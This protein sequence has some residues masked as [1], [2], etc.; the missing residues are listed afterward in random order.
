MKRAIWLIGILLLT[1]LALAACG[2]NEEYPYTLTVKNGYIR[3]TE[4][5]EDVICMDLSKLEDAFAISPNDGEKNTWC[6][7]GE[8]VGKLWRQYL[9]R[10]IF[11]RDC[12]KGEDPNR[13]GNEG[14]YRFNF[15][16][17]NGRSGWIYVMPDG[18]VYAHLFDES[19]HPEELYTFVSEPGTADYEAI[20]S[21]YESLTSEEEPF[22]C[23]CEPYISAGAPYE[24]YLRLT[25]EGNLIF[26]HLN[27]TRYSLA[28]SELESIRLY[29]E[30]LGMDMT[31]WGS[32]ERERILFELL[33]EDI[34][35]RRIDKEIERDLWYD[36]YFGYGYSPKSLQISVDL[37]DNCM[38]VFAIA[39]NGRI[40]YIDPDGHAYISA[41]DTR[42][43][44]TVTEAIGEHY[45]SYYFKITN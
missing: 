12:E 8:L 39:R 32:L 29:G 25:E 20:S 35:F 43:F 33:T 7:S 21:F 23:D 15:D 26:G 16:F 22:G 42:N 6:Y 34:W 40:V 45:E 10:K 27:Q 38:I 28:L 44:E 30:G 11:L 36:S 37:N 14:A 18:V 19:V 1:A 41:P 3:V 9:P 13:K 5:G 24:Y 2:E 4:S 31:V 17:D